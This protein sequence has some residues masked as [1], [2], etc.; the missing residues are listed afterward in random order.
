MH[1]WV[2]QLHTNKLHKLPKSAEHIADKVSI[3]IG[4]GL[5]TANRDHVSNQSDW[6]ITLSYTLNVVISL[7]A[8]EQISYLQSNDGLR[9]V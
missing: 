3:K 9:S 5:Y 1:V 6:L 4:D 7:Q 8:G 2:T